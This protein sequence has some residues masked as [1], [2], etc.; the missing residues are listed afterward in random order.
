MNRASL[1]TAVFAPLALLLAGGILWA[2]PLDPPAGPVSG[3]YKTLNEVEPRIAINASNTPGDADSLFRITAPGSYYLSG[4]IS[5]VSGKAGIEIIAGDVTIDLMGFELRGVPGSLEGIRAD[6]NVFSATIR[7]G[8]IRNWGLSGIDLVRSF[9]GIGCLIE[10]IQAASNGGDGIHASTDGVVRHCSTSS[11]AGNGIVTGIRCIVSQCVANS[12]T[13]SGISVDAGC[14]V[15]DCL[16]AGNTGH[17]IIA[18]DACRVEACTSSNNTLDGIRAQSDSRIVG[19]TCDGNG[20]GAGSGAGIF[21]LGG[22]DTRVEGNNCTDADFGIRVTSGGNVIVRNTCSGNTT[23]WNV[24]SGNVVLVILAATSGNT[25]S[26]DA[27]G[28]AP[29]STD[30]NA[31]FTY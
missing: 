18:S 1:L 8:A 15:S 26:G 16:T 3:T 7:N 30:P 20:F 25:I 24:T 17:G 29:G 4:N 2:G 13:A 10:D 14:A 27:G 11:N 6:S 5:C 23:N 19:N 9:I 22:S 31:N 12:N 28:T 21:V